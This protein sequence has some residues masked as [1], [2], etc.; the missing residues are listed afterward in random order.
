MVQYQYQ[1]VNLSRGNMYVS[2]PGVYSIQMCPVRRWNTHNTSYVQWNSTHSTD[3]FES[4]WIPVSPWAVGVQTTTRAVTRM[5]VV[6][7]AGR[8]LVDIQCSSW[9]CDIHCTHIRWGVHTAC[10][11]RAGLKL[12][13]AV[14]T[15]L[16]LFSI[17]RCVFHIVVMYSDVCELIVMW[18]WVVHVE[19]HVSCTCV[20][21]QSWSS[22]VDVVWSNRFQW[23]RC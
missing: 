2:I 3:L 19:M 13:C 16:N 23:L 22:C 15:S 11:Y 5:A 12:I 8:S 10:F 14:E 1:T 6:L 20:D 18:V 17:V 21:V 7:I 4:V 9:V